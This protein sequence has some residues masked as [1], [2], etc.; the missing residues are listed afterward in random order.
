MVPKLL[1]LLSGAAAFAPAARRWARSAPRALRGVARAAGDDGLSL[2]AERLK[3]L[4][5]D[6]DFDGAAREGAAALEV[7]DKALRF[8]VGARVMCNT[9]RTADGWENGAVVKLYHREADWPEGEVVPYQVRL[10]DGTLIY[11]PLDVDGCVRLRPSDG[12]DADVVVVGAGASG[13]GTAVSLTRAFGLDPARVRLV[14]RG[15]AVGASFRAWPAEMRFISPSFNQQGWTNSFDL[16]AVAQD[17][18]PAYALHTQHP[19][20]AEYA[21][22]LEAL[23]AEAALDVRLGT[24][25]GADRAPAAGDRAAARRRHRRDDPRAL[26]RLGRGRVPVP[27]RGARARVGALRPQLAGRVVATSRDERVVIGGY[28][29]GVDAAVNLARAG[30]RATVLASTATW[31][32]QTPD[33]STELAPY[34]A[35]RLRDV[36]AEGF[37]PKPKLLAPL[38]VLRVEAAPGAAST[39]T[40]V[41]GVFLVGPSVVQGDLS[42]CFVYKFRQR[43]GIVADAICRGLGRETKT[44]VA[45]LRQAHM[46]D[47]SCCENVA[48][49]LIRAVAPGRGAVV[50][51]GRTRAA[52]EA[53]RAAARGRGG[54]RRA[55]GPRGAV[56]EPASA[57]AT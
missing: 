21:R 46:A 24:D 48:G 38:R 33:P 47:L 39:S 6:E 10:D 42:F 50:G 7:E 18:S 13:V 19:S 23:V 12:L 14:D 45:G 4:L 37:S 44:A 1:S 31:N 26:R 49:L 5:L 53:P 17:T 3:S 43:F 28:E 11:A 27:A 8:A 30:K 34:T 20:G 16:N 51:S 54:E 41:P 32:V 40:K 35:P 52:G 25:A 9:G 55:R 36:V 15:D 57:A 56:R 22:Y 2:R 29:S